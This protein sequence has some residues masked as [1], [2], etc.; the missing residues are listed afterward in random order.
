M[1]LKT[2]CCL[3]PIRF[4]AAARGC[5][6]CCHSCRLEPSKY[7]KQTWKVKDK[8]LEVFWKNT[9]KLLLGKCLPQLL[10]EREHGSRKST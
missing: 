6:L 1:S 3:R 5:L 2:T 7:F 4:V 10:L 8:L 9:I